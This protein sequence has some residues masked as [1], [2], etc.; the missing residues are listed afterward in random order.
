[1]LHYYG[2]SCIPIQRNCLFNFFFFSF[3]YVTASCNGSSVEDLNIK[4]IHIK[5][6]PAR[7]KWFFIG[8]ALKIDSDVLN[9]IEMDYHSDDERLQAVIDHWL[10][11]SPNKSWMKLA[12]CME[13]EIVDE[14]DI[15]KGIMEMI[16]RKS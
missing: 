11:N 9:E 4:N 5:L 8:L 6:Y 1:M 12:K 16:K 14:H 7:K 10:C 2:F 3:I 15:K 13:S